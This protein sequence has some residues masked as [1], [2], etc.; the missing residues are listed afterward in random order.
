MAPETEKTTST[1]VVRLVASQRDRA[2]E[3]LARAFH[4]DPIY[5]SVIPEETQR[6]PSLRSLFRP[7]VKYGLLYGEAYSTSAV[8]GAACWMPPGSTEVTVW[9]AVRAGMMMIPT[10]IG[11]DAWRRFS[12]MLTYTEELHKRLMVRPHWYLWV[13]GVEPAAQG[14][15]VGGR[16]I[17]LVLNRADRDGVPCYLETET[18]WNAA[19]YGRRG[20]E[21]TNDGEIPELGVRIWIMVRE[22]Q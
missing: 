9:R 15:G 13:L 2:A 5:T 3:V 20:F 18:E 4:D 14:Q 12:L 16:L 1:E 8:D 10:R 19:F 21:V 7:V 17:E 22:P 6:F 11:R